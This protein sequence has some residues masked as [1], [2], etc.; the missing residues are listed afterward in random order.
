MTSQDDQMVRGAYLAMEPITWF[1]LVPLSLTSLLTGL[2]MALGTPWGLFRHYWVIAKLLLT[3]LATLVLLSYTQTVNFLANAAADPN[4]DLSSLSS[5]SGLL[6]AGGGLVVLLLI[7]TLSVYK[8]QGIT[9]YGWRKQQ[10]K[11]KTPLP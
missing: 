3:V 8:P 7:M 4:T 5:G 9:R 6:H 1:A 2:V 10:E 11:R